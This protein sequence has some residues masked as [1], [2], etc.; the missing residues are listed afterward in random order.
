VGKQIIALFAAVLAVALVVVGCGS[1][2]SSTA[3]ITK[4]EFIKQADADCKKG[5][6][7]IQ[8]DLAVYLKEHKD[9]EKPTEDDYSEL[10]E[11]VLVPAA[12]QE[13]DDIRALGIP[14]GDED[15]VEAMLDAREASIE[16][17]QEEPKAVVQN[18]GSVFGEA[19]KLAKEYGLKDC[20]NR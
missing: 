6:E 14:S 5:E 3:S 9:L 8:K 18:G 15:Q 10:V 11:A 19:S 13:I 17:A 4:A 2:D 12:E 20:G 16:K 1:S 7:E